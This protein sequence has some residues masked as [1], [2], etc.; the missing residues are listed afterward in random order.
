VG[1]I[2]YGVTGILGLLKQFHAIAKYQ[3]NLRVKF[4][5]IYLFQNISKLNPLM[6]K[7]SQLMNKIKKDLGLK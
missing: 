5:V 1:N 6:H 2:P 4:V 3:T 7:K